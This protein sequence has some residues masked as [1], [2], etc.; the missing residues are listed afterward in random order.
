MEL[1]YEAP[2]AISTILSQVEVSSCY[3]IPHVFANNVKLKLFSHDAHTQYTHSTDGLTAVLS[4][5][6][7]IQITIIFLEKNKQESIRSSFIYSYRMMKYFLTA[8]H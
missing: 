3:F 6:Y 2:A 1:C 4:Q 7:N 5:K 8:K